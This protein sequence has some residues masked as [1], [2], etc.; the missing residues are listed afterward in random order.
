MRVGVKRLD[1][2]QEDPRALRSREALGKS[3]DEARVRCSG[4]A[5]PVNSAASTC[6]ECIPSWKANLHVRFKQP[7]QDKNAANAKHFVCEHLFSSCPQSDKSSK[8]AQKSQHWQIR[9]KVAEEWKHQQS[10]SNDPVSSNSK[11]NISSRLA[12]GGIIVLEADERA[13][14]FKRWWDGP[15]AT[16]SPIG[17]APSQTRQLVFLEHSSRRQTVQANHWQRQGQGHGQTFGG[18]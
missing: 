7:A 11:T 16:L 6:F 3:R 8:Q 14:I 18:G 5:T 13:V 1:K 4:A 17:Q 2:G 10:Y 12:T 15:E 9:S